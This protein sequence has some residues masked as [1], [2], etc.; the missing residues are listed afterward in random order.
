MSESSRA[1]LETTALG[2]D[3]AAYLE[4]LYEQF[5]ADSNSVDPKWR[6]YFAQVR[7]EGNDVA[8]GPLRDALAVRA[9]EHRVYA[10][11]SAAGASSDDKAAK[12]GAVSRLMQV[13]SNRG[14]LI[15]D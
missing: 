10:A 4:S 8:H 14:H 13:Y 11:S 15:A 12:Q 7:K 9:R 2:A 3:Q 5:L 1:L 6:Q